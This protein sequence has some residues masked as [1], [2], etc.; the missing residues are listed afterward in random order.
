MSETETKTKKK[1]I[2]V[3]PVLSQDEMEK[4]DTFDLES[5]SLETLANE[6][7]KDKPNFIR[8]LKK[9]AYY[10]A[11]IGLPLSESC[12]LVDID[13]EKFQEDMKLE[14]LIEKIIK[15]KELEYKKDLL[16]T[17]S[18]KARNGDDKLAQWLLE[19][20]Y[21]EEFGKKKPGGGG[22]GNSDFMFEAI[23][24]IQKNGSNTPLINEASG[25]A[26]IVKVKDKVEGT[27]EMIND[28]LNNA[29]T[30]SN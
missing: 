28:I 17:L 30:R 29:P 23:R 2:E 15:I 4:T 26:T 11:K 19:S 21:P 9:I 25:Q 22:D 13:Y 18:A 12:L 3:E 14:P 10:T 20:K 16:Y 6:K 7:F 27:K 8:V 24:F 5:K 1:K